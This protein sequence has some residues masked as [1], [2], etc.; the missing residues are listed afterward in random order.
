L[1][2]INTES[3]TAEDVLPPSSGVFPMDNISRNPYTAIAG[4]SPDGRIV[5]K[6][7]T[8]FLENGRLGNGSVVEH[9]LADHAERELFRSG[10]IGSKLS[11]FTASLTAINSRLLRLT[12]RRTRSQ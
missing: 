4:W 10:S 11:G 1:W 9:R 3:G 2:R 8:N 5:Y 6:G 7:V 12:T